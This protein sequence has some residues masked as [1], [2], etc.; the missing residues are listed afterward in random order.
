MLW[1]FR[2]A[3]FA[4]QA[5]LWTTLAVGFGVLAQRLFDRD[6]PGATAELEPTSA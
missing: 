2:V 1:R 6:G 5:A 4:T 3:S